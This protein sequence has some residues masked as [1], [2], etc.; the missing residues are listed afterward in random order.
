MESLAQ[1]D[2]SGLQL[3]TSMKHEIKN[4]NSRKINT[5]MNSMSTNP[6]MQTHRL[7][8]PGLDDGSGDGSHWGSNF[9]ISSIITIECID[10]Q[11]GPSVLVNK[12]QTGVGS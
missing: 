8:P 11:R 3:D 12:A 6:V 4:Q 9:S 10:I 7:E 1:N 5:A 2:L